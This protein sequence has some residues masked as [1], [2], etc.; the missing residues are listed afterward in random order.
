M[1]KC[2]K[3]LNNQLF[4]G[5]VVSSKDKTAS[6]AGAIPCELERFH[7]VPHQITYMDNVTTW[8]LSREDVYEFYLFTLYEAAE[9]FGMREGTMP[10][11]K[12][13]LGI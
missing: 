13:L 12:E 7:S 9:A 1:T 11:I 2:G 8:P 4:G 3:L 5:G 6:M 10:T